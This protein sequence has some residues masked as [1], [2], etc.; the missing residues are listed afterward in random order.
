L[1]NTQL[2]NTSVTRAYYPALDG[3]RGIAILLV[4]LYHNFGFIEH[5]FF[6]WLG[7]DLFFVLSG[8]LIT[9]IILKTKGRENFLKNFYIRRALRIVPLFYFSLIL[10]LFV[11]P[12]LAFTKIDFTFYTNHQV[13]FWLYLQ[14]FLLINPESSVSTTALHH[15]W[16]LAVE[17]QFYL[18]WPWL[19]LA[20]P[21]KKNLT[22]IMI[23]LLAGLLIFRTIIWIT[24]I[25]QFNYF[26]FYTF[27][28]YDGLLIGSLSAVLFNGSGNFIR[29]FS[30]FIIL[31]I[32][33][34]NFL[35]FFINKQNSFSFPYLAVIG[36]TTFAF[37]FALLVYETAKNEKTW[38]NFF[39][40]NR[41]LT[42][43]GRYSYGIYVWHWPVYLILSKNYG[44]LLPDEYSLGPVTNRVVAAFTYSAVAVFI[45]FV[46]F[47]LLEKPFLKMKKSF[48]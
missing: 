36:Y 33:G 45:S 1:L 26:G 16:S 17:E 5:F 7:V 25:K 8:F 24:Q 38:L 3:L 11:L 48:I 37:L 19:I 21:R 15:F 35:F 12:A 28:R 27:T 14:N 22:A 10:F 2:K 32:A 23:F 34:L 44:S 41:I 6:G 42:F 40:A 18:V 9:D 47:H 31:F 30:P 13:W 46:S 20:M 4:L 39:L 43:F 29:K